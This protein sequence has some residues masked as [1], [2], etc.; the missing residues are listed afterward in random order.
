MHC[1]VYSALDINSISSSFDRAVPQ[2]ELNTELFFAFTSQMLQLL[3]FFHCFYKKTLLC[4]V[5]DFN[6]FITL[7]TH[8]GNICANNSYI[9]CNSL[10]AFFVKRNIIAFHIFMCFK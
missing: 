2:S 8:P 7:L 5:N 6:Q 10:I 9:Y 4:L 1:A 3:S